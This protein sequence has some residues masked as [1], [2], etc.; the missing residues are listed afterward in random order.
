[1]TSILL[2]LITYLITWKLHTILKYT[3]KTNTTTTT[4]ADEASRLNCGAVQYYL[5]INIGSIWFN[6]FLYSILLCKVLKVEFGIYE[7]GWKQPKCFVLLSRVDW[8]T[9]K[10]IDLSPMTK[11]ER[12]WEAPE[13]LS[14]QTKSFRLQVKI[15]I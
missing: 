12:A 3:T 5:I 4:A 10:I 2:I 8:S 9:E 1:M 14:V 13:V 6:L 7:C 15:L 11:M